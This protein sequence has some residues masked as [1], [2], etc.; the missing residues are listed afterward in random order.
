MFLEVNQGAND[1]NNGGVRAAIPADVQTAYLALA[2]Y[3]QGEGLA[4]LT[5][6]VTAY[7]DKVWQP[8]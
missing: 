2:K 3:L 5:D 4:I 8:R 7:V 1:G 6:T